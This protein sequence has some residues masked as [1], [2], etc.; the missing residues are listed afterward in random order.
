MISRRGFLTCGCS[1]AG[2]QA[3]TARPAAAQKGGAGG[4]G[5]VDVHAHFFPERFIRAVNEQGGP[6]GV[7]FDLSKPGAPIFSTT[8]RSRIRPNGFA[9]W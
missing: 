8:T 7:S 3:L 2:L 6:P 4:R 9:S 5:A 1:V